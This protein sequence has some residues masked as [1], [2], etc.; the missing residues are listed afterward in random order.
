[1]KIIDDS[2]NDPAGL[3]E[4]QPTLHTDAQRLR[5]YLESPDAQCQACEYNLQGL[6]TDRCPECGSRI[7]L[8]AHFGRPPFDPVQAFIAY[9]ANRNIY[10]K[11]CKYNLK[12]VKTN[13]C[14]KCGASYQLQAG[15]REPSTPKSAARRERVRS[16][17]VVLIAL[18]S[19]TLVIS[20]IAG[21]SFMAAGWA[22]SL[23]T[24]INIGLVGLG[25]ILLGFAIV[26]IS[27]R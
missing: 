17:G 18:G 1:M 8:P 21:M 14:P 19:M 11:H 5:L 10:C 25:V 16:R 9:A 12:G 26:Q 22:S 20:V 3:T 6:Q 2:P 4:L 27:K 13:I 23:Q 7:R 15:Y 24:A